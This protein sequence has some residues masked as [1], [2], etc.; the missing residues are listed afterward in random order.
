MQKLTPKLLVPLALA[1]LVTGC[2]SGSGVGRVKGQVFYNDQPLPGADVEFRPESET[3][4]G[5][6]GGQTDGEG[7]FDIKIGKGTGMNAQPG[8]Y[9]VLISKGKIMGV[10]APAAAVNEEERVKSLM[11]TG[12]GGPGATGQGGVGILPVKYGRASSTPFKVEI[13]TGVNDLNPFR[14]EG[15][16]LKK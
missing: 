3:S 11:E 4:L 7:H 15:P 9:V 8:R 5:S 14:M 1:L 10:P 12:P 6:F 16:P 13:S 2:S